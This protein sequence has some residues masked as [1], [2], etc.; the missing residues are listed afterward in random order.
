VHCSTKL[1][2]WH[3]VVLQT[4]QETKEFGIMRAMLLAYYLKV[5][6]SCSKTSGSFCSWRRNF[7]FN[8][9]SIASGAAQDH[10]NRLQYKGSIND[11][12]TIPPGKATN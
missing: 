5:W 7:C 11:G 4:E 12:G 3:Q 10:K 8:K 1:Q 9:N 2:K 6:F